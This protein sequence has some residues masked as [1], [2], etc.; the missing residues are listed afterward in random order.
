MQYTN[1]RRIRATRGALATGALVV[2]HSPTLVAMRV[3]V[4]GS[5]GLLGTKLLELLLRQ[6]EVQA[7]GI[8]RSPCSNSHLGPFRFWQVDLAER[9]TAERVFERAQPEVVLHTAAMTDVDACERQP[10]RAWRENVEA[11]RLVALAAKRVGARLVHLSTEYVFDGTAGPYSE[12]DSPNPLCVY[13]RTKL[14]SE[15]V[16]LETLPGSAIARTTVLFGY[17]PNTRANFVTGLLA[18]LR[19]SQKVRV[20]TDQVGSPTLADNLARM[21]WT[22]G[23]DS[24]ALGVF[25]AVGASVMDRYRFGVL[26]A[27]VFDLDQGLIEPTD[28]ASLRQVAPRPLKAGLLMDKFR[29]R[30]PQVPVLSAQEALEELRGQLHV[31]A[32]GKAGSRRGGIDFATR[33]FG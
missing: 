19:A 25:N 30:Y 12:A 31:Y 3:L 17:A 11:T 32:G 20:V 16:V 29:T 7:I 18:R 9:S 14:A 22:L 26:V 1:G 5:N 28:T 24:S 2:P 33:M 10:R 15:E 4:T 6:P 8:S 21:V 23:R 27:N 13:G